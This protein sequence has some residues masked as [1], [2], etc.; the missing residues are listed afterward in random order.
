MAFGRT[1]SSPRPE[2]STRKIHHN[3]VYRERS[4]LHLVAANLFAD[5]AVKN[6]L[7]RTGAATGDPA[8][9]VARQ[10]L[11]RTAARSMLI[12]CSLRSSVNGTNLVPH[13]LVYR[14]RSL[15]W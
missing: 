12:P 10:A 5:S 4:S 1:L 11:P 14:E 2:E 7:A 15:L 6:Q 8:N 13:I 9:R 3:L